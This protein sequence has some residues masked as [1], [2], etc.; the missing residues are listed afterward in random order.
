MR[1]GVMD[2]GLSNILL[3]VRNMPDTP[4]RLS[5]TTRKPDTAPPRRETV[6]ASLRLGVAAEAQRAFERTEMYMPMNPD[7]A[8]AAAP[9]R[10][11]MPVRSPSFHCSTIFSP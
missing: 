11:A 10:K 4:S 3:Y 5:E 6:M 1:K 2:A 9:T 7:S 8:D